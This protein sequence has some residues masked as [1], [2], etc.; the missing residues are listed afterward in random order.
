MKMH[1]SSNAGDDKHWQWLSGTTI[2]NNANSVLAARL[3][4]RMT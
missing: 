1:F 3:I 2:F 4:E